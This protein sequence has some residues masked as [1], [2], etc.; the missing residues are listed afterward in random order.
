MMDITVAQVLECFSDGLLYFFS[1]SPIGVHV[2]YQE[3]L[4]ARDTMK[5]YFVKKN[6]TKP[7]WFNVHLT[8][9]LKESRQWQGCL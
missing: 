5:F 7:E 1:R 8:L 3:E 6:K 9:I 2:D 4:L